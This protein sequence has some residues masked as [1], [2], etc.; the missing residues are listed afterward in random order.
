[1]DFMRPHD[2][3]GVHGHIIFFRYENS[4]GSIAR[5]GELMQTVDV[6][7]HVDETIDHD[8]RMEIAGMV[9]AHAGVAGVTHHDEKPHLMIV[10]YDP[11]AVTA[12]ALLDVVLGKGV[13]AELV[14]L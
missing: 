12:H 7:I 9:R 14:G 8:K 3:T 4:S 5:G 11:Q 1:M 10:K 2:F 6:I 13:H